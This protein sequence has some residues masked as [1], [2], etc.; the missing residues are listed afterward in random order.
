M[1]V[2]LLAVL[3]TAVCCAALYYAA[4]RAPVNA[5]A[6]DEPGTAA[7]LYRAQ[8]AEIER[9]VDA[10]TISEADAEAARAELGRELLR[11][12]AEV[13]AGDEPQARPA[14]PGRLAA[15]VGAPVIAAVAFATYAMLGS[16]GLPALPAAERP[17]ITA[18]NELG[19]AIALVEERLRAEPDDIRG[20]QVLAPVYMRAG[21]YADAVSAYRQILDL[22]GPT[23]DRRTDLAEAMIFANGGAATG[24]ALAL[25]RA[26]AGDPAHARS[27]FYLA[28]EA[29]EA[30]R[31]AEA[32]ALWDEVLALS[33]DTDPWVPVARNALTFVEQELGSAAPRG[34]SD[35]E[36]AAADAMSDEERQT[37]I[38]GMVASLAERLA[39][40]GGSPEEWA[41][42]IRARLVQGDADQA[43]LDYRAA[44][45]S[46][47]D[48][49]A[50]ETLAALVAATG[51]TPEQ[52]VAP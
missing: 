12:R 41:Q 16:P 15:L 17:E 34:P 38:A 18:R 42:L 24:E 14:P 50:R 52:G 4:A 20:W 31:Y 6:R 26:A 47:D 29:T 39:A 7:A 27:R 28:G 3:L 8:L 5:A 49:A 30:G 37:M 21:R 32:K 9:D 51:L 1:G 48:P 13:G 19:N 40:E 22:G 43:R 10:G 36:I 23:A 44:L 46:L 33:A 25:L 45:A 2:W 35:A 11:Q